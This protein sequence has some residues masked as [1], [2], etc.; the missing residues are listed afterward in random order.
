MFLCHTLLIILI[1]FLLGTKTIG[2]REKRF[3]HDGRIS[4][5]EQNKCLKIGNV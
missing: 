5:T 3:S 1:H 2:E 4:Y